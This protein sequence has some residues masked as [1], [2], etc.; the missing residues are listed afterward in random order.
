MPFSSP[1]HIVA[2]TTARGPGVVIFDFEGNIRPDIPEWLRAWEQ[3]CKEFRWAQGW[4]DYGGRPKGTAASRRS[5]RRK[6]MQR[7]RKHAARIARRMEEVMDTTPDRDLAKVPHFDASPPM[8]RWFSE[9]VSDA[10]PTC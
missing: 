1:A 10:D 2:S 7:G 4:I 9:E 3:Y 8:G 5:C 6:R